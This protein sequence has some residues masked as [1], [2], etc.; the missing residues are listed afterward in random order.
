MDFLGDFLV[1]LAAPFDTDAFLVAFLGA[2]V[3]FFTA[4]D[5]FATATVV[6]LANLKLSR[7]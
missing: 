7:T 2:A 1:A 6:G 5:V 3:G 4:G